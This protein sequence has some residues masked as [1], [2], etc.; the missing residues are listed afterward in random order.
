MADAATLSQIPAVQT[1]LADQPDPTNGVYVND[2]KHATY[3]LLAGVLRDKNYIVW[4]LFYKTGSLA[5]YY[6]QTIDAKKEAAVYSDYVQ[7]IQKNVSNGKPII[8]PVY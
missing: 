2:A 8:S 5:L 1:F 4:S 7:A 3:A 6:P